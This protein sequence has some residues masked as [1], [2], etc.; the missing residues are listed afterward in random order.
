MTLPDKERKWEIDPGM[1]TSGPSIV[2]TLA[3]DMTFFIK[4]QLAQPLSI[5]QLTLIADKPRR[6]LVVERTD[7]RHCWLSL[8]KTQQLNVGASGHV[9]FS[10]ACRRPTV[11]NDRPYIFRPDPDASVT[12][13]SCLAQGVPPHLQ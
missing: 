12:C 2:E 13:L 8:G 6:A 3:K 4:M 9:M 10:D 7:G 11:C 5:I 1:V